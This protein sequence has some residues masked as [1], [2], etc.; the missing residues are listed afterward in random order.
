MLVKGGPGVV[1]QLYDSDQIETFEFNR[2]GSWI[3]ATSPQLDMSRYR[4]VDGLDRD[5]ILP[6][7]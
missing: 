2:R 4:W 3:K 7:D 6:S 1:L 5:Y